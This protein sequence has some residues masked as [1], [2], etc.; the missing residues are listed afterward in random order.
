[1]PLAYDYIAT[2][3]EIISDAFGIV[4]VKASNRPLTAAQLEEGVRFLQMMVK[5]WSNKHLF[6]WSFDSGSF[7]TVS[8]QEAY[9][10]TL[11]QTII[12]LDM[13][14][15]VDSSNDVPI[16]V[17]S[18]DQ[19]LD[20]R[21]KETNTGRPRAIAYKPTPAPSFYIWPSPDA[22]YTV[23]YLAVFPLANLDSADDSG[24]IPARFQEALLYGLAYRLSLRYPGRV[25][26]M[27]MIQDMAEASFR[28]AKAADVTPESSEEV[29]PLFSRGRRI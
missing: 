15:V 17:I 1:M 26:D 3:N 19:Y 25:S 14:W 20:F 28:D 12:G 8:A 23:K 16:Q 11:D 13:A 2:R 4:G 24:D 6:L 10:S 5:A 18:Y 29:E 22:V 7:V 27:Q 9:D 21:D